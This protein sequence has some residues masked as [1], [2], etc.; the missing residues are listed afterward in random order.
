[1]NSHP[2]VLLVDDDGD[3]LEVYTL[4]LEDMGCV[5]TT[6]RDG[7]EGLARALAQRPDL[8]ITDLNMPRMNG[9]ELCQRLREDEFLRFVPRILHS[10]EPLFRAPY[11]EVFLQKDGD[12]AGFQYRVALSL[13]GGRDGP[14]LASVA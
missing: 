12:L 9:L 8:I 2:R 4:V 1:M 10:S 5:V 13:R 7:Q 6:A 14:E 11:G 3:L